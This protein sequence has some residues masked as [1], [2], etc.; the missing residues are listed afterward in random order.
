MR[1]R[2]L[3]HLL[4][5]TAAAVL[6]ASVAGPASAAAGHHPGHRAHAPARRPTISRHKDVLAPSY[7]NTGISADSSPASANLD[8]SGNSY[9]QDALTAAGLGPGMAVPAGG[10]TYSWP[11]VAPGQPDNVEADGQTI[12]VP[13]IAGATSIGLIGSATDAGSA[14]A[15]GTLTVGFTDGSSQQI[16]VTLSDWTLGGGAFAPVSSDT[17]VA[18]MGYR[19]TGGAP[20]SVATYVFATSAGLNSGEIVDSVTLPVSGGGDMHVFAVGFAASIGSYV[21]NTYCDTRD[22]ALAAGDRS[23]A[24]ATVWSRQITLHLDD[25]DDMGWASIGNGSPT[26]EVWLDRSFDGGQTWTQGSKLGDTTI[27]SGDT[28]WR[29]LMYNVDDPVAQGVGAIRACGKA[30]N[31]SDIACT[32]WARTTVGAGTPS[33]AAA[34]ALM[35]FWHP[36]TGLWSGSS[37]GWQD[38]NSLTALVDYEQRTGDSTYDYAIADLYADNISTAQFSDNYVDDTGWW[39]LAWLAAY[40]LTGDQNYLR[41]AEYDANF[42]SGYW[43]GTCGGGVWWS[44]ARTYKNAIPNEL[45]L[46]LNAELHNL[47]PDDSTYLSRARQEWSWFAASGMINSSNLVNDGLT[48]GCQNNGETTWTYNQGVVLAGLDQLYQADG[49]SSLLGVA[50]AIANAATSHLTTNG[51]LVEPCEPTNSCDHDEHSFKGIFVRDLDQF[52]RDTNDTA[53]NQFLS[54]QASSILAKDTDLDNQSG[55]QWAGPLVDVDYATQHA[56]LDALVTQN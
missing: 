16:P 20:Q 21:C 50:Q 1:I 27:P 26:D 54:T 28:G 33:A 7:D 30:G 38:A 25:A 14:G 18:T 9:S 41:T 43:D 8:G 53:Y 17:T 4:L 10:I 45:Y 29:T 2:L 55:L 32:P 47:L 44:T 49:D 51:V 46:E 5:P 13:D 23:A 37:Y 56:A 24:T 52:A 39:G 3:S 15:S 31:R 11:N 6:I 34:T 48:S 40:Q 22:P 36:S 12:S 19:N 42:M 35:Q